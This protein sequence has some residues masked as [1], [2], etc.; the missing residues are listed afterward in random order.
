MLLRVLFATPVCTGR[1]PHQQVSKAT[2][3]PATSQYYNRRG[4]QKKLTAARLGR[5][6]TVIH[7]VGAQ[8]CLI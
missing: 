4:Y 3:G 5:N 8:G 1:Q 6:E 2:V 7:R